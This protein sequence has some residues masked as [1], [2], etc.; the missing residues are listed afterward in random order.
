MSHYITQFDDGADLKQPH[1]FVLINGKPL[2]LH[3]ALEFLDQPNYRQQYRWINASAL[4]FS[5][6]NFDSA[7]TKREFQNASATT[8]II[9]SSTAR[10][11]MEFRKN[12]L[13]MDADNVYPI[14]KWKASLLILD[15]SSE[16]KPVQ[17][18]NIK[19]GVG[20]LSIHFARQRKFSFLFEL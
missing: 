7:L 13:P 10:L 8:V 2:I 18:F 16:S 9:N 15:S 11:R 6:S 17:L 3:S 5:E 12:H 19:N 14:K 1:N 20:E 4:G